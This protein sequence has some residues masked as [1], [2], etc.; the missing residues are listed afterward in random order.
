MLS[1]P[2]RFLPAAGPGPRLSGPRACPRAHRVRPPPTGCSGLPCDATTALCHAYHPLVCLPGP[3]VLQPW[4]A[5]RLQA[6]PVS[7]HPISC[8]L[9]RPALI[10][11]V[12]VPLPLLPHFFPIFSVACIVRAKIYSIAS[13][14]MRAHCCS[15]VVLSRVCRPRIDPADSEQNCHTN[16]TGLVLWCGGKK[17]NADG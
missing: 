6:S 1:A 8:H 10:P 12:P 14:V 16:L 9:S 5:L 11:L 13:I 2:L 15:H 17:V 7:P 4:P 3:A